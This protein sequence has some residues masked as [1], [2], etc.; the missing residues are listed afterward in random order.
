MYVCILSF[1]ND[2]M[3]PIQNDDADNNCTDNIYSNTDEET[4]DRTTVALM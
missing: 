4:Y 2:V 3:F 1:S